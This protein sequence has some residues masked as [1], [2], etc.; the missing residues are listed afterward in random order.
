MSL[1]MGKSH[2]A[3]FPR[4]GSH[5]SVLRFMAVLL[6]RDSYSGVI[7]FWRQTPV[8]SGALDPPKTNRG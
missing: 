1:E 7:D 2:N 8:T 6:S 3:R 5:P 4:S